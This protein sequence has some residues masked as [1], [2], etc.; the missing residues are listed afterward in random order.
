MKAESRLSFHL[1]WVILIPLKSWASFREVK[2]VC[3]IYWHKNRPHL[4]APWVCS[5]HCALSLL[6]G[7]SEGLLSAP[8]VCSDISP[9]AGSSHLSLQVTALIQRDS[10]QPAPLS[11]VTLTALSETSAF[12]QYRALS[13]PLED[14][15]GHAT[16][17]SIAAAAHWF[18]TCW[19]WFQKFR[20]MLHVTLRNSQQLAQGLKYWQLIQLLNSINICLPLYNVRNNSHSDCCLKPCLVGQLTASSGLEWRCHG[21]WLLFRQTAEF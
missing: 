11:K 1:S 13:L 12:K 21:I 6:E 19:G 16:H 10:H 18:P 4:Q 2:H 5:Y 8:E 9:E 3:G 7:N 15:Q 17:S 14:A 20:T